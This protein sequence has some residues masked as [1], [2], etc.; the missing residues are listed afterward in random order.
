M[1]K[2]ILT[3]FLL[4]CPSSIIYSQ[5]I[6]V[7][8]LQPSA[9]SLSDTEMYLSEKP[10]DLSPMARSPDYPA[11]FGGKLGHGFLNV[12]FGLGS[13]LAGDWG[14]GIG[15]T[16]WQGLGFAGI[17]G[18]GWNDITGGTFF[19]GF[20]ASS[21][22]HIGLFTLSGLAAGPLLFLI[23]FFD[24]DFFPFEVYLWTS[25]G[26]AVFGGI[27][28]LCSP[29]GFTSDGK[30]H[31]SNGVLSFEWELL[32]FGI[33]ASGV[34]FGIILPYLPTPDQSKTARLDDPRNWN[35]GIAPAPDGRFAGQ[36]AFTAHF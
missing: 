11:G 32:A 36:I 8:N 27:L 7:N 16:L 2:T 4:L 22:Q 15:L 12:F 19:D 9:F 28:G 17:I 13:Y 20:S 29:R 6:A 31:Q 18:F 21:W 3:I 24:G 23:G 35:I 14:W 5:E 30:N 33:W 26:C 10:F 25:I 34:I 1:K